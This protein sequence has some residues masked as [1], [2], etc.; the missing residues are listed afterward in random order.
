MPA[1]LNRRS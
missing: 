1:G